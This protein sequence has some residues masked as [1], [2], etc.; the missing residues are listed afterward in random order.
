MS[1][2]QPTAKNER[3]FQVDLDADAGVR[4]HKE[5]VVEDLDMLRQSSRHDEAQETKLCA[6]KW[7]PEGKRAHLSSSRAGRI[8]KESRKIEK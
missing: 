4:K 2:G 8:V 1:T 7:R 5:S 3:F 6:G